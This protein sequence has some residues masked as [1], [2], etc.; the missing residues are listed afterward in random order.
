MVDTARRPPVVAGEAQHT[1]RPSSRAVPA[2]TIVG[3]GAFVLYGWLG[4][5]QWQAGRVNAFDLGIFAQIVKSWATTGVPYSQIR[6]LPLFADHF[7]PILVVLAGAWLA[8]PDPR[9]LI[10]AQA[11][12]LAAAAAVMVAHVA[13][14]LRGWRLLT[15]AV[16]GI[17]SYAVLAPV[18]FDFHEVAFAPLFIASLIIGLRSGRARWMLCGAVGLI[19][20]KEDLGAVVVAAGVVLWLARPA[21]RRL[22]VGLA[23]LGTA[24]AVLG[25][26][27][28]AVWSHRAG[29]GTT[30][31]HRLG[32]HLSALQTI[33]ALPSKTVPAA[34]F[35]L[36]C[37]V[38]GIRHRLMLL[39]IPQLAWR[40]ISSTPAYSQIGWQYDLVL[41]PLMFIGAAHALHDW[42]LLHRG[43]RVLVAAA[44]CATLALGVNQLRHAHPAAL[45]SPSPEVAT[46]AGLARQL[47]PGAR[48]A[49]QDAI[50]PYLVA[51]DEVS[52]L[53]VRS[54]QPVDYVILTDM[55]AGGGSAFRSPLCSR[56][57]FLTAATTNNDRVW[58]AHNTYLIK[59]PHMA[60]PKL[61]AC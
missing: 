51:A 25:Y 34:A 3:A 54:N 23:V 18:L 26:A 57:A 48:V 6:G 49:A 4:L 5:G 17:G 2:G 29:I 50:A 21:R 11:L 52:V 24:G 10:V 61:P 59:L 16:L 7:S 44:A 28:I 53:D 12:L 42:P 1:G 46:I 43:L 41:W 33:E 32:P 35:C 14:S 40:A 22:A 47:P 38:I 36:S 45:F 9:M 15:I 37:L 19:L 30:Y 55:P 20:T 56:L 8:W 58:K 60:I 31:L 39:A 13:G 27:T